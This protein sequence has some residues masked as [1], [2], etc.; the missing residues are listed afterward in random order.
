MMLSKRRTF[1][2]F[3]AV[4]WC[5]GALFH[6]MQDPAR[7][8][9]KSPVRE[10]GEFK[11]YAAGKEIGSE[12][13]VILFSGDAVSS[14]SVLDFR[15][16]GDR[17]QR[18]QLDSKLEMDG[19]FVPKTYQLKSDVDGQKGTI[20]GQFSAN[21]AMFEYVGKGTP[22]KSGLLVGNQ[23][24]LLDTNIFHHF[25]FLARLFKYESKEK[26]QSFEVVIPQEQDNGMLKIS[27]LNKETITV[28][29]KKIEAHHLQVDSGSVMIHLWVD[30]QKIVQ[31]ITV[32]DK[33]IE[34]VRNP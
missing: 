2:R 22:K 19:H 10:E 21:Q 27:N 1:S 28:R 32:P 20:N 31:K 6:P 30:G 12:K 23:F 26:F 16:P 4:L 15:N 34:V 29:G 5:A 13:Y 25:V 3:V 18:V 33:Q 8:G 11:I 24:T 9:D 7:A 17:H 14:T